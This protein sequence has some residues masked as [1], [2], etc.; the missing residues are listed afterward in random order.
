LICA[1]GKEGEENAFE[2]K[3]GASCGLP[4]HSTGE[5]RR[6]DAFSGPSHL[7]NKKKRKK[8]TPSKKRGVLPPLPLFISMTKGKKSETLFPSISCMK[9]KKRPYV[10]GRL[11]LPLISLEGREEKKGEKRRGERRTHIFF[12]YSLIGG[13]RKGKLFP[14]ERK[15]ERPLF[16]LSRGEKKRAAAEIEKK[17]KEPNR[18]ERERTN[19]PLII[20]ALP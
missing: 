13:R 14:K 6:K 7:K 20:V 5:K 16:R 8:Q 10:Q 12:I 9:R 3:K 11:T 2:R 17:K 18:E 15:K 19:F 4:H 1:L